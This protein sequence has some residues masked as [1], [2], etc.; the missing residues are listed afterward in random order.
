M[1]TQ[2]VLRTGLFLLLICGLLFPTITTL[3]VTYID[4]DD[5]SPLGGSWYLYNSTGTSL[6]ATVNSGSLTLVTV[7]NDYKLLSAPTAQGN[8]FLHWQNNADN[9]PRWIDYHCADSIA[10][11]YTAEYKDQQEVTF[12][13]TDDVQFLLHDPWLVDGNNDSYGEDYYTTPTETYYSFEDVGGTP[14]TPIYPYY[15][16]KIK[17][18]DAILDDNDIGV[19]QFN[20][21]DETNVNV[22]FEDWDWSSSYYSEVM[23]QFTLNDEAY[24]YKVDAEYDQLGNS[25]DDEIIIN[26]GETLTIPDGGTLEMNSGAK[27]TAKGVLNIGSTSGSS[28]TIEINSSTPSLY[29]AGIVVTQWGQLTIENTNIYD[30]STGVEFQGDTG[31]NDYSGAQKELIHIDGC[32]FNNIGVRAIYNNSPIKQSGNIIIVENSEFYGVILITYEWNGVFTLT[33]NTFIES[34]CSIHNAYGTYTINNNRFKGDLTQTELPKFK[35]F[36]GEGDF[37]ISSNLFEGDPD[38]SS[39]FF[40]RIADATTETNLTILQNTFENYFGICIDIKD[41]NADP[42]DY[43]IDVRSN[44]FVGEAN[45]RD[46]IAVNLNELINDGTITNFI[47]GYNNVTGFDYHYQDLTGVELGGGNDLS[48]D[49]I[50]IGG[51][52]YDYNLSWNSQ[53]INTGDPDQDDDDDEWDEDPDDRDPDGSRFDIGAFPTNYWPD[54][55]DVNEDDDVDVGDNV[56]LVCIILENC[57]NPTPTQQIRGDVARNQILEVA[58]V[59]ALVNCEIAEI[60]PT[61]LNRDMPTEG[62]ADLIVSDSPE[63]NRWDGNTFIVTINSDVPVHGIQAD[64]QFENMIINDMELLSASNGLTLDYNEISNGSTR[65]L[66]YPENN[67]GI[68]TGEN[69]VLLISFSNLER[70]EQNTGIQV[71]NIIIVDEYARNIYNSTT[72]PELPQVFALYAAYP[73]PFNPVTTISYD[74]SESGLVSIV[75][76]DMTGREVTNLVNTVEETGY[77]SVRWDAST[78]SSGVYFVKMVSGEFTQTQKIMLV[79]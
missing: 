72:S 14:S 30:V 65:V 4:L 71:N 22:E 70:N 19:Y 75:I 7:G 1:K 67:F 9:Y 2:S 43:N 5:S 42:D 36:S 54:R 45:D 69:D 74:L 13:S 15:K 40:N 53:C 6:L 38:I 32:E 18:L 20:Q 62:T 48:I 52:P 79:K 31:A 33:N 37:M 49:P 77:H 21:F 25:D 29:W 63:L 41:A 39:I 78:A 23:F 27:F 51:N 66:I 56:L 12:L 28:S 46:N 61:G 55:G 35:I 11:E 68:P 76:Y 3:E 16:V 73:N 59:V 58:D 10:D 57:E 34:L 44:I 24:D 64:F 50:F 47:R 26:T 60:C 8:S 17:R